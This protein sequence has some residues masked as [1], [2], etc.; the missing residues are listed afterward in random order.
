[1][2][3]YKATYGLPGDQEDN[4]YLIAEDEE[5][6]KKILNPLGNGE[7]GTISRAKKWYGDVY[8]PREVIYRPADAEVSQEPE[9]QAD[10]TPSGY[11]PF[12]RK[13]PLDIPPAPVTPPAPQ[14]PATPT[15]P[16]N[17]TV[18]T[19]PT[20]PTTPTTGEDD[21]ADWSKIYDE[22]MKSGSITDK[23]KAAIEAAIKAQQLTTKQAVE[24]LE[25]EK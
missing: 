7:L 17:P 4:P 11:N 5:K 13:D 1:M 25:Y 22:L 9:T 15:E 2:A 10:I 20:N 16:T 6:R 14:N 3:I 24:Q 21:E 23:Y 18:P 19:E 8:E 12:I